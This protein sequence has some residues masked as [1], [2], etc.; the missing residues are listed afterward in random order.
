MSDHFFMGRG[1][2]NR[3]SAFSS[4]QS[5]CY[6]MLKASAGLVPI[7]F[8]TKPGEKTEAY[9]GIFLSSLLAANKSGRRINLYKNWI[10]VLRTLE[11]SP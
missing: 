6:V 10:E 3:V 5:S 2:T 9:K 7:C 8:R 11:S 4:S 1:S